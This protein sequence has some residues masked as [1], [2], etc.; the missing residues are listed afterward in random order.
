MAERWKEYYENLYNHETQVDDTFVDE[1]IGQNDDGEMLRLREEVEETIKQ[2]SNK[3][4]KFP[5]KLKIFPMVNLLIEF[6]SACSTKQ[7]WPTQWT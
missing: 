6:F 4:G 7:E 2:Y 5:R 1:S 3:I